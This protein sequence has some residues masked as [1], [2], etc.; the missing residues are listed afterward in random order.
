MIEIEI[1]LNDLTKMYV[2][3]K[4]LRNRVLLEKVITHL[5][6]YAQQLAPKETMAPNQPMQI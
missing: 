1:M 4:S 6:E 2:K 5:K 3:E